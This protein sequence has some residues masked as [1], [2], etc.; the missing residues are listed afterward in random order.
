[1]LAGVLDVSTQVNRSFPGLRERLRDATATA[2]REL[3]AL[4]SAFDL[5]VVTGYRRFLQASAGALL[6]LED[7]LGEADVARIFPDWPE[8][9]RSAA[10]AAD[11]RRLG[12][13]AQSTM[14]VPSLTSGGILGTM[15]V[16]EGSRLGA[17]FL[18]KEIADAADPRITVATSY[19]RH[20]TGKR[21]WQSFLSKLQSEEISDEDQVIE[22]ARAAFTAFKRAADRA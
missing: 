7:A 14:P 6:P 16:L 22:A 20:G 13:A 15:Y 12:S 10:I 11:L 2:H 19:L 17:R 3:D 8:R 21:L 9:S 5:T 4:L 1:M 18:L